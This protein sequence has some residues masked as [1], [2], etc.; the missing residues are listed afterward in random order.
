M[1]LGE[2]ALALKARRDRRL[3]ELGQLAQGLPGPRVVHALAGV[4][5]RALGRHQSLRHPR[6]VAR[7]GRRAQARRRR[8][9]D[10]LRHLL[11]QEVG[12]KLDQNRPR[13][14]VLHLGERAAHRVHDRV[15]HDDLLAPL[16][17]VLVVQERVEVGLDV[18]DAA[19]I[20]AGQHDDPHR[21]AVGLGHTAERVLRPRPVLHREDA[22]AVAR[23]DA[24]HGVG[25]VEPGPL[26]ADDDRPD[27]RLRG[28]LDDRVDRIPDEK[29][30]AFP[31][32]D[33]RN[34]RRC[35]H[36][37]LLGSNCPRRGA[38]SAYPTPDPTNGGG[39][40]RP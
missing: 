27:I 20:A 7:I 13:P 31:L 9:L 37:R 35:L 8:V 36:E 1:R 29:F 10:R 25:H 34:G 3:Q 23:R 4:D 2:R 21:I 6:H 5:D 32:E 33:L 40:H 22:D 17:D 14:A 16:G 15:G 30:H 26:L 19:R 11:A 24:A 28:R 12:R 38:G 39:E 18:R